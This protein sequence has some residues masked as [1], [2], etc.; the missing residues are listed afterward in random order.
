MT[1]PVTT[2]DCSLSRGRGS[3]RGRKTISALN[4][5]HHTCPGIRFGRPLSLSKNDKSSHDARPFPLPGERVRERAENYLRTQPISPH[6][7]PLPQGRG[8]RTCPGVKFGRPLS[9]SKNDKSSYDAR[10]FPLP[11]EKAKNRHQT[12]SQVYL[13]LRLESSDL[14][15]LTHQHYSARLPPFA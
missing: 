13:L 7:P 12:F 3:G 4:Q 6:V 11:G 8:G 9:L 1:N 5:F 15:S 14:F 10:L 2:P